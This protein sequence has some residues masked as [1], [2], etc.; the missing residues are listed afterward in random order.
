MTINK[1]T[2]INSYF[3]YFYIDLF[4][5]FSKWLV[6]GFLDPRNLSC[7]ILAWHC[8]DGYRSYAM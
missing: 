6:G 8:R 2:C 4:E 3:E 7:S 5:L 1:F